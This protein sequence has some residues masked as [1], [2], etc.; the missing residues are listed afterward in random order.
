M[1]TN[2]KC[3]FINSNL[4]LEDQCRTINSDCRIVSD[5]GLESTCRSKAD[6]YD[7]GYKSDHMRNKVPPTAYAEANI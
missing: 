4:V 7:K 1:F 6:A 3:A 2:P 5:A